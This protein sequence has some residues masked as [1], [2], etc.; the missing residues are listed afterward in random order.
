MQRHVEVNVV[1]NWS[2]RSVKQLRQ[3]LNK[4]CFIEISRGDV[5]KTS[6]TLYRLNVTLFCPHSCYMQRSGASLKKKQKKKTYN[7]TEVA[8]CEKC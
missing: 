6:V 2:L 7:Y 1:Q 3:F 5:G 8:F 4:R